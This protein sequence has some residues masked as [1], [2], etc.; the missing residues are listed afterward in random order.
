MREEIIKSMLDEN[1]FII[2]GKLTNSNEDRHYVLSVTTITGDRGILDT[3]TETLSRGYDAGTLDTVK[4]DARVVWVIGRDKETLLDQPIRVETGP[5]EVRVHHN[6]YGDRAPYRDSD[7]TFR[8]GD[9]DVHAEIAAQYREAV[10]E[11]WEAEL[12]I[13]MIYTVLP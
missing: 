3:I 4:R 12:Y 2:S 11:D 8:I 5:S 10:R 7:E 9:V 13:V 1:S 6:Y